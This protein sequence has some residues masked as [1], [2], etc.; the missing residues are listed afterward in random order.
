MRREAQHVNLTIDRLHVVDKAKQ[1]DDVL[2]TLRPNFGAQCGTHVLG[3]SKCRE[4]SAAQST[5]LPDVL[6]DDPELR[7]NSAEPAKS[8]GFDEFKHAFQ[9]QQHAHDRDAKRTRR[10]IRALP[11]WGVLADA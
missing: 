8:C 10:P 4:Q 5:H 6:A 9:A 2:K 3:E 7:M 1:L 11:V